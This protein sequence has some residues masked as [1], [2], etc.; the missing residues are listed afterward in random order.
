MTM[1]TSTLMFWY[2]MLTKIHGAPTNTTIQLL[3]E[4]YANACAV[5]ST[6]GGGSHGHLRLVMPA[7]KYLI[8]AHASFQ[9]PAH[10]GLLP[11]TLPAPMVLLVPKLH[12]SM[13]PH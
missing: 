3:T 12:D 5:S 4:V 10:P 6:Q 13:M 8:S 11:N 2:L 7:G 9:L 1:P